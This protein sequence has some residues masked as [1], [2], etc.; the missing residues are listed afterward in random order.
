V[1]TDFMVT[2]E[3]VNDPK[4]KYRIVLDKAKGVTV[5]CNNGSEIFGV[6]SGFYPGGLINVQHPFSIIVGPLID[7]GSQEF[8]MKREEGERL[9]K[10]CKGK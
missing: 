10:E 7:P 2:V 6:I 5:F 8:Q 9:R 3:E 4:G 1:A